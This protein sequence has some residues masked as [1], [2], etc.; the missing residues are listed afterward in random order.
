VK[1]KSV[2]FSRL[3][4]F[5]HLSWAKTTK[6]FVR[7][8]KPIDIDATLRCVTYFYSIKILREAAPLEEVFL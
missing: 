1:I 4:M 5:L 7:K 2:R 3:V 8:E 6:Q